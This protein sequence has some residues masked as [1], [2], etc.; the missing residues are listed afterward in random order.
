M[1]QS[2]IAQLE[3]YLKAGLL[4]AARRLCT[5]QDTFPYWVYIEGSST[6]KPVYAASAEDAADLIGEHWIDRTPAIAERSLHLW[7]RVVCRVT[8]EQFD[9]EFRINPLEPCATHDFGLSYPAIN[10]HPACRPPATEGFFEVC[11]RTGWY[12]I[13]TPDPSRPNPEVAQMQVYYLPPD[14]ASLA[15]LKSGPPVDWTFES[16]IGKQTRRLRVVR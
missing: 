10:L 13:T 2:F 9:E 14:A 11:R 8:G 6:P 12:R 7:V 15:W 16:A 4:D 3:R 5:R 1:P